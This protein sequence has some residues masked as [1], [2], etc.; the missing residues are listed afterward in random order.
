MHAS[1]I[2]QIS[3]YFLRLHALID[4]PLQNLSGETK[5]HC[6]QASAEPFETLR[7]PVIF[8]T[9]PGSTPRDQQVSP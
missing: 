3:R 6:L 1:G 5:V 9:L 7:D 8:L 2:P 4:F